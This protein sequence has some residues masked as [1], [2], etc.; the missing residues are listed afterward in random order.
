MEGIGPIAETQ[1]EAIRDIDSR[2]PSQGEGGLQNNS[3][4]DDSLGTSDVQSG[5][6]SAETCVAGLPQGVGWEDDEKG[7]F[8]AEQQKQ[9]RKYFFYDTPLQEDTGFWIPVS[10]P[11]MFK[12]GPGDLSTDCDTN[13]GYFPEGD[14]GWNS[15]IE[16]EKELTMWDIIVEMILAARGKV[17]SLA[18]TNC[19][20]SWMSDHLLEQAWQE[21]AQTLA[22]ASFE[23]VKK[24]L[25]AEPLQWVADSSASACMLCGVRFHPIM[26]SRS[27]HHCRFCGGVFCGE[28][29]RGRSLLPA[30]FRVGDP[31]RVCDVCCVKLEC[32][33]PYLMDQ[34]SHAAQLQTQDL[35]DLSTLRSWVNFPWGQSMEHEIYKATNTI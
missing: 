26:R 12:G 16:E 17:S 1:P 35:T 34:V 25:E 22:D 18:P 4:N 13:G 33:Q 6:P 31:Q 3:L 30:K 21:M 15:Y 27:R 8:I 32:V 9:G 5:N 2:A 23:N 20:F 11:P 10:V 19:R 28:C 24:I 14:L 7:R 29:S